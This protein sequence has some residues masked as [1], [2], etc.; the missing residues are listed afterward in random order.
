[1]A[2]TIFSIPLILAAPERVF[3]GAKHIIIL[4]RVRFRAKI[5]EILESLKSWVHISKVI[6]R[7]LLSR[8]F[9]NSHFV[10]EALKVLEQEGIKDK[11]VIL[12]RTQ[13]AAGCICT[14]NCNCKH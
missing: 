7:A 3:S 10:N 12:P 6:G 2:I 13:A 14:C 4:E 1:M 5:L 9:I 11:I 8:I